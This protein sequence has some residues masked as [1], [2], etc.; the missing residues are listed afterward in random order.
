MVKSKIKVAVVCGGDSGEYEISVKSAAVVKASLDAELIDSFII[1]IQGK[2]WTY[3]SDDGLD[4]QIDKNDFS[5]TVEGTRIQF[6]VAFIAVHGVPGEDGR[7]QGYF[8]MMGIPYTSSNHVVSAV[9]FHKH[10]CKQ[11]VQQSGVRVAS[12]VLLRRADSFD[13]AELIKTLGLPLFVK[14]NSNGSSVGVSKVKQPG[15]LISAI[16]MAFQHDSEILVESA[17]NGREVG[18]GVFEYLGRMMVFPITEIISRKEFFDYEAKYNPGMSEEITP[19]NLTESLEFNIKATAA[20][21][22]KRIGCRGFVRFDFIISDE[23]IY[24]LEVNIVP[25][26]SPA[27]IVPQ[28]ALTMGISLPDLF[29]M[30]V[31]NAIN[32]K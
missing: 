17:I 12:S 31:E 8:D 24:F 3:T 5:L 19:A 30:A 4:Y 27:S 23:D 21:L 9:T 25:G 7:L 16:E 14:P 28:Q 26:L 10:F 29:R 15:E 13:D 2:N 6:D 18:C 32:P 11:L 22:Y 1:V 20:D